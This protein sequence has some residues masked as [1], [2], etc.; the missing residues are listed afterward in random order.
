M[1]VALRPGSLHPCLMF[2]ANA[3]AAMALK[4]EPCA[5][6]ASHRLKNLTVRRPLPLKN[7]GYLNLLLANQ[8]Q[9]GHSRWRLS[10]PYL[11]AGKGPAPAQ[12]G[13]QKS[14]RVKP[15]DTAC[16]E[17]ADRSIRPCALLPAPTR[18]RRRSGEGVD[19]PS[20]RRPGQ[21]CGKSRPWRPG[22]M[23]FPQGS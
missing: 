21:W 3:N 14:S 19:R 6:C 17:G 7:V 23:R 13:H 1:K 22:A 18:A 8:A 2:A 10:K 16:P 11:Q 20:C 4:H 12:L 5:R 9:A 15:C